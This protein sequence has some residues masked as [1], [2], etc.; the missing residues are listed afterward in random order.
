MFVDYQLKHAIA[1]LRIQSLAF[2]GRRGR[3]GGTYRR[4]PEG[5]RGCQ[6]L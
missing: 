3:N 6:L 4:R 1:T 2:D 5:I